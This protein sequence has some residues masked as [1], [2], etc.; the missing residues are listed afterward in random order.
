LENDA[1]GGW[2]RGIQP[3]RMVEGGGNPAV[4]PLKERSMTL[5]DVC[6]FVGALCAF[7]ALIVKAI[8]VA[9]KG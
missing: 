8:E 1:G 6:A 3:S 4:I 5:V 7:A 9:R 2:L